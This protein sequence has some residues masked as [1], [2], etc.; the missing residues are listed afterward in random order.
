MKIDYK[1]KIRKSLTS[2]YEKQSIKLALT[3]KIACN[4]IYFSLNYYLLA[5]LFLFY[6]HF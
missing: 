5:H 2:I 4:S 3:E 6:F 1:N